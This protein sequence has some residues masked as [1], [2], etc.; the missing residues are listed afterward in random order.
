[1]KSRGESEGSVC[2]L[3]TFFFAIGSVRF[4]LVEPGSA[5]SS[6]V[7]FGS[8]RFGSVSVRFCLVRFDAIRFGSVDV[9]ICL[10]CGTAKIKEIPVGW[11]IEVV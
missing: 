1:M 7:R 2:F 8:V 6:S 4:G 5:R 11:L 9:L 3:Q 10:V